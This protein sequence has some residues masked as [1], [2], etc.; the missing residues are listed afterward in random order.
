MSVLGSGTSVP[1]PILFVVFVLVFLHVVT[2]LVCGLVC[3]VQETDGLIEY[4]VE[5]L[6][7]TPLPEVGTIVTALVT[8]E[9]GLH[10]PLNEHCDKQKAFLSPFVLLITGKPE[11]GTYI[12]VAVVMRLVCRIT[13]A[14]LKGLGLVLTKVMLISSLNHHLLPIL[15]E[16]SQTTKT[17][18]HFTL[19]CS[20]MHFQGARM[21]VIIVGLTKHAPVLAI[22]ILLLATADNIDGVPTFVVP[23]SLELTYHA[24]D[25]F[26]G[27]LA[28]SFT[29]SA[30]ALRKRANNNICYRDEI[31][32]ESLA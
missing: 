19:N 7:V 23:R 22:D 11:I 12:V 13:P 14:V 9:V 15:G 24:V 4:K 25:H 3:L 27:Y 10:V 8:K 32:I 29:L 5:A 20:T 6:L 1:H 17:V 30:L 2:Y 16:N 28:V 26:V 31:L 18:L 21:M